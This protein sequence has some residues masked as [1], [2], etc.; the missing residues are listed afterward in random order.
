MTTPVA[1][2][3]HHVVL[4]DENGNAVGFMLPDGTAP[5]RTTQTGRTLKTSTGATKYSDLE[6]PY[7]VE[8]QEDMSGGRGLER[9]SDDPSRFYDSDGVDTRVK[10]EVKLGPHLDTNILA[11]EGMPEHYIED[12]TQ[13]PL[14]LRLT[15]QAAV[16]GSHIIPIYYAQK[17]KTNSEA[18]HITKIQVRAQAVDDD[19]NPLGQSNNCTL[20]LCTVDGNDYPATTPEG[21]ATADVSDTAGWVDFT[22]SSPVAVTGGEEYFIALHPTAGGT[23]NVAWSYGTGNPYANGDVYAETDGFGDTGYKNTY[24]RAQG[25]GRDQC[26]KVYYA[27]YSRAQSFVFSGSGNYD[28]TH[29]RVMLKKTGSV[30]PVVRIRADSG[31]SPGTVQVTKTV[32]NADVPTS[33]GWVYVDFG[34]TTSL[35]KGTTYWLETYEDSSNNCA[36]WWAGDASVGYSGGSCKYSREG[37]AWTA[38]ASYDMIF[39]INSG[40]G[41]NDEA[42]FVFELGRQVY[43]ID[44]PLASTRASTLWV[45]GDRGVAA[46]NSG[47]KSKLNVNSALVGTWSNDE[48]NGCVAL[49][50]AG[51]G[52]GEWREI[53]DTVS[54]SPDYLTV[55]DDW[56]ETH[57]TTTEFVILGSDKWTQITPTGDN[58]D[59]PVS[60]VVVGDKIAH[61]AQGDYQALLTYYEDNNSGTWRSRGRDQSDGEKADKLLIHK[62][63]IYRAIHNKTSYSEVKAYGTDL[64]FSTE[65]K[66]GLD[67]YPINDM[68]VYDADVWVGKSDSLW[69]DKQGTVE[70]IPVNFRA[71]AS[72]QNCQVLAVWDAYL[73]FNLSQSGGLERMY[74]LNVDDMGPNL[75]AG[76]L[77]NRQGPITA[78][79]P[80]PGGFYVGVNGGKSGYSSVLAYNGQGWHEIL[81]GPLGDQL[82]CLHLQIIPGGPNRLMIGIGNDVLDCTVPALGNNTLREDGIVFAASGE[83]V[84]PWIDLNLAAAEKFFHEIK[85]VSRNVNSN[86]P[87]EVEYQTDD[88]TDDD[89]WNEIATVTSSPIETLTIPDNVTGRRIRFKFTLSTNNSGETPVLIAWALEAI[90]RINPKY[91]WDWPCELIDKQQLLTGL[92]DSMSREDK[93]TQ[94]DEWIA[95]ASPVTYTSIDPT[96]TGVK[97]LLDIF[98]EMKKT[99]RKRT[100]KPGYDISSDVVIRVLEV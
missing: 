97:V 21:T 43:A 88:D 96:Q 20:A 53:L 84:T 25:S 4:E 91:Q 79:V 13:R 67:D 29:C 10:N 6:A 27:E 72:E 16:S 63:N 15:R 82:R 11:N 83:V 75:D 39:R 85:V 49:I 90:S 19:G 22:F 59:Y 42:A 81:R 51:A 8:A 77:K 1:G 30:D 98:N 55:D 50:T 100:G 2:E 7:H 69:Q 40:E 80:Y 70:Q 86:R 95:Q 24:W 41:L 36:L 56:D 87:I 9:F 64:E 94:L 33:W 14:K 61:I 26:F 57:D 60:D 23:G 45:N 58:I 46:S 93:Y 37:G 44:K 71:I 66:V 92:E 68:E 78:F 54:G 18:T 34:S 73:F 12:I 52:K 31:G 76:M 32:D 99:I 65:V 62:T 17:F 35:T 5:L 38:D 89:A 28:V 74:G 3:T 47:D 48:F